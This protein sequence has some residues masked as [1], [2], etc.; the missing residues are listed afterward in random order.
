MALSAIYSIKEK[1]DIFGKI[2]KNDEVKDYRVGILS[3]FA[4]INEN[5]YK[6]YLDESEKMLR[7]INLLL[8]STIH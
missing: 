2:E 8:Y 6:I 1:I 4:N 7:G 3:H 5:M